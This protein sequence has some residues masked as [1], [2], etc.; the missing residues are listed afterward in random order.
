MGP[1]TIGIDIGQQRDRTAIAVAEIEERQGVEHHI[2][3]RLE[4]LPLRTPY[5]EIAAR[6]AA[7][8][9]GV[10]MRA[11]QDEVDRLALP[12]MQRGPEQEIVPTVYV[13]ATGLG[14]PLMDA[15]AVEGVPLIAVYF[16][17]GDKRIPQGDRS[18]SLGKAWLVSRLQV[19]LQAGRVLLPK[20]TEAAALAT[21]LQNY[22]ITMVPDANEHD[23]AFTV[24]A[25][26]DLVTALGLAVQPQPGRLTLM[27]PEIAD[28]IQNGWM[29][30][31]YD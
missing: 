14:K 8:V 26:D 5:H 23:G 10:R 3:R 21:D 6:L 2:I 31:T 4:R 20:T 12:R 30:A 11:M 29:H 22:E 1:V 27:D 24:G 16:T 28:V 13:D 25:H 17:Y 18:I 7:V 15:L 19:L 9:E